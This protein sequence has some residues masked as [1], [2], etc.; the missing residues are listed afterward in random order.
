MHLGILTSSGGMVAASKSS[1]ELLMASLKDSKLLDLTMVDGGTYSLSG[2][3][4]FLSGTS[5]SNE[6]SPLLLRG[7]FRFSF[8]G[9][10][11]SCVKIGNRWHKLPLQDLPILG[12][13]KIYSRYMNISDDLSPEALEN[14]V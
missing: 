9:F 4:T 8:H 10:I 7:L 6:L 3:I 13:S 12:G 14:N 5:T 2:D 1:W 11:F